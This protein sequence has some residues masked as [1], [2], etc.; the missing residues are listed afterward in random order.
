VENSG[1]AVKKGSTGFKSSKVSS[2]APS[3]WNLLD[4]LKR[5][6]IYNIKMQQL[7]A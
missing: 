4:P 6:K 1:K 2:I 5:L 3:F 7:A